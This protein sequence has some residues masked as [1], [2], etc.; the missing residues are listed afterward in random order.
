MSDRGR[1][2]NGAMRLG[3]YSNE[4]WAKEM[5]AS[6]WIVRKIIHRLDKGEGVE[7]R[8]IDDTLRGTLSHV[9]ASQNGD[10]H[11]YF[12]LGASLRLREWLEA[13]SETDRLGVDWKGEV[14]RYKLSAYMQRLLEH[15]TKEVQDLIFEVTGIRAEVFD[16]WLSF[17]RTVSI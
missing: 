5:D 14:P 3:S 10:P 17:P 12:K 16:T 7:V 15:R 4:R 2:V 6:E 13:E 9:I 8:E 1:T 11:F